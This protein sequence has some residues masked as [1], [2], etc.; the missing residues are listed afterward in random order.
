MYVN[1]C[2]VG[3]K[4]YEIVYRTAVW[5]YTPESN[6]FLAFSLTVL[7]LP[8]PLPFFLWEFGLSPHWP[9]AKCLP[10]SYL[11]LQSISSEFL[12]L[13]VLKKIRQPSFVEP[14]TKSLL[15]EIYKG[16]F[17]A[18]SKEYLETYFLVIQHTKAEQS[19]PW[20]CRI[21]TNQIV[22]NLD[23]SNTFN[24]SDIQYPKSF[25]MHFKY[26]NYFLKILISKNSKK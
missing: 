2:L 23:I 17:L 21:L 26:S 8:L 9:R 25:L 18:R 5:P 22:R 4:Q 19:V 1:Q 11:L 15:M 6:N 13:D 10:L 14:S 7:P 3:G 16:W 24:I 12:L 20:F